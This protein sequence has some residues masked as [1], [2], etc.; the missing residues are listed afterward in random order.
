MVQCVREARKTNGNQALDLTARIAGPVGDVSRAA[1]HLIRYLT[2]QRLVR[3]A[4]ECHLVLE[5]ARMTARK[6]LQKQLLVAWRRSIRNDYCNQRI[7][8][9]RSLQASFWAQLNRTLPAGTRRMFIEPCLVVTVKRRRTLL[10][11]DIVIC[12]TRQVIAVVEIKY[13]PRVLPSHDKDLKTLR[14]IA[15]YRDQLHVSNARFRGPVADSKEYP[16]SN[17]VVFVWAGVHRV[18]K[19]SYESRD[20]PMLSEGVEELAGCFLQL[21]AETDRM[22]KPKVFARTD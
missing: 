21:H 22:E 18:P 19:I 20:V 12:N 17:H 8:S 3:Y 10:Y 5:R 7:N 16:F 9:E 2:P 13:Q 15:A 1:G 14:T 6:P 11:P 4:W